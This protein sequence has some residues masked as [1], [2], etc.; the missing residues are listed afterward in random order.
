MQGK[1]TAP[2]VLVNDTKLDVVNKFTYL[3]SC[4]SDNLSLEPE[5]DTRIGKATG[6]MSKLDK[7]VWSN[8]KLTI[9]TKIKVY[10]ACVLSTLLYG[11]ETCAMYVSLEKKLNVFHL[12]CLRR[13]LGITWQDKVTNNEVLE[14]AGVLSIF[15][16]LAQRRFRWTGHVCRMDDGRIPKDLFYGELADGSRPIGRPNLR[17]KDVLK[18]DMKY[19][20][21]SV[22]NWEAKAADRSAWR[23]ATHEG[24]MRA[25][26]RRCDA[27]EEKRRARKLRATDAPLASTES[28]CTECGRDFHS[29]IG[30]HSHARSCQLM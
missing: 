26:V 23:A 12:R 20:G 11:S 17:Y 7:K 25:E 4:I 14:R 29:R 13:I 10:E 24:V 30:L 22:N 28:N 6:V 3:G 18:R 9:R 27:A 5:V 8:G 16:L 1:N 19:S 21:I 15:G 2:S